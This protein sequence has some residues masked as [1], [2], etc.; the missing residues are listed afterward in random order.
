MASKRFRSR[1]QWS[2]VI[3]VLWTSPFVLLIGVITFAA[4]GNSTILYTVVSLAILALT[5]ALVRDLGGRGTY[6]LDGERLTL[7]N[8]RRGEEISL[9]EILDV[10]LIDRA[11]A[12]EYILSD[13]RSKGVSGFFKI[14][15]RAQCYVQYSSVDIGLRSYTLGIGRRMTDRM[16]DARMDLVL[17]RLRN[18]KVHFLTPVYNQELV[19]AITRRTLVE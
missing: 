11:G 15:H 14:R 7:Q 6:T 10:S 18:G 13:L 4:L 16:P 19:S 8:R 5:I 3:L 2:N 12:R 1:R 9:G 17:V